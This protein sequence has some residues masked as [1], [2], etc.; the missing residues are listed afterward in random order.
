MREKGEAEKQAACYRAQGE[1]AARDLALAAKLLEKEVG[2]NIADW[3]G[4][5]LSQALKDTEYCSH[6]DAA[7]LARS[8]KRHSKVAAQRA[9]RLSE[10][11]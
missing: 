10:L 6:E 7:K 8:Y 3:D 11:L 5:I 2:G 4:R 9:Q 1:A